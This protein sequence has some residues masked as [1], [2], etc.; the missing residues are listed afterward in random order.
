MPVS[1][2]PAYVGAGT[3]VTASA[4]RDR[5]SVRGGACHAIPGIVNL[6]GYAHG[7]PEGGTTSAARRWRQLSLYR[8]ELRTNGGQSGECQEQAV[9]ASARSSTC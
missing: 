7:P 8:A 5:R 3:P 2:R 6:P 1:E 9:W 4:G